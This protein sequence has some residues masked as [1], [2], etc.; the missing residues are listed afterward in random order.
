MRVPRLM[1]SWALCGN[2]GGTGTGCLWV[3]C[4]QS[5]LWPPA[6]CKLQEGLDHF[7]VNMK[8]IISPVG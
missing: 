1:G 8:E 7:L 3:A 6:D 5:N 4:L 2:S